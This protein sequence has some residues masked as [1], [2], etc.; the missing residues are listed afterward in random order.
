MDTGE[1]FVVSAP[2]G[3]G[4]TTLVRSL[5]R[6][7]DDLALAV[8]HTTRQRREHET[9]GKDYHFISSAS[10]TAMIAAEEFLEYAEVFDHYYGTSRNEVGDKQQRGQ[11]VLLEIDWQGAHQIRKQL[12]CI[13]I[14]ILPPSFTALRSRISGRGDRDG[15]DVEKRLQQARSD[16][17]QYRYFDYLII[18]DD[19]HRA[20]GDLQTIIRTRR[21]RLQRQAQRN[22]DLI[23]K[24]VFS[25]D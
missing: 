6:A 5:V 3:T 14:F 12:D 25:N 10:F 11:D 9:D 18:N 22:S 19:F 8:S 21:L 17:R 7:T 23:N 1:L 4:K 13:S 24:L 16:V 15:N 20:L 2:S